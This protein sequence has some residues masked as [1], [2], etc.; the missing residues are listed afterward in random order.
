MDKVRSA[1]A[2]LALVVG[3]AGAHDG[4]FIDSFGVDGREQIGFSPFGISLGFVNFVDLAVQP[5]GKFVVSAT[6]DN[7]TS[8]DIGVLRLNPNGTLDTN[9][10][11]QGQRITGFDGGGANND[12]ATSVL[13]QPN[14]RIV[15]CGQA[16]GDP[17]MNGSDF[18]IVRLTASGALDTQFNADGR[19]TVAFDL[20]PIGDRDDFAIRC[21]LQADGKIVA[22]GQA[23]ID[24]DGNS[25][26]AVAR[27][28]TD[29]TRDTGFNGAGTATV[30]F[31]PAFPSSTAFSV[32][33]LDDGD[34]LLI[35]F[36]GS[37]DTV[38][39]ASWAF[40]RL[41]ADGTLDA[42]FGNGGIQLFDPGVPG[43]IAVEALDAVVLPDGSF[44]AAG[45]MRLTSTANLD[46]GIFKLTA[47]GNLD[48][49]FGAGGGQIIPFD[50]GSLNSDLAVEIVED[51]Q[52]RFVVVGFS[53]TNSAQTTNL[54]RL[55]QDG[56]LDP[57]FGVNGKLTVASAPP[58][59]PD[60]GDV[61]TTL[62]LTADGG[63]LIGS[64]AA[65]TESPSGLYIGLAKIV[66]DTIFDNGF[67]L[68]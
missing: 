26:M 51:G 9:F 59:N 35:G 30:D 7:E 31:G 22:A 65:T 8:D 67:D 34:T 66:A 10:G 48:A 19:T 49:S 37:A 24:T 39:A 68:D 2:A 14:G 42:A 13:L 12:V 43:Y 45:I 41:D 60:A 32:K 44:V 52:G 25:R 40:A 33:S 36:A 57:A 23:Q 15:I 64:A 47:S 27:L 50:L 4:G 3:T 56:E 38:T 11:I 5:D 17:D 46:V 62:G 28:E 54:V 1:L 6:V 18:G 63:V 53:A 61:G 58:P 20:G 29:G 55:T 16:S 21:S